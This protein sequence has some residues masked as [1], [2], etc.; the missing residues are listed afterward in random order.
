MHES[1]GRRIN[2]ADALSK[3]FNEWYDGSSS[4]QCG[5]RKSG[6]IERVHFGGGC[7]RASR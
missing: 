2:S 3:S 7:D 4:P 5:A 6:W 1:R